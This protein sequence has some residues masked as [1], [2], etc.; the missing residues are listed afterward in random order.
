MQ[1]NPGGESC[2]WSELDFDSWCTG[3]RPVLG[4]VAPVS[5]RRWTGFGNRDWSE[6]CIELSIRCRSGVGLSVHGDLQ[7]DCVGLELDWGWTGV[8][9]ISA[10]F[11]F[12]RKTMCT[13]AP[14]SSTD[15]GEQVRPGLRVA[16]QGVF[17]DVHNLDPGCHWAACHPAVFM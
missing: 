9:L 14:G 7:L 3:V 8:G 13:R 6:I 5:D 15:S 12:H 4:R 1:A 10:G 2:Q 11:R 17:K 16:V